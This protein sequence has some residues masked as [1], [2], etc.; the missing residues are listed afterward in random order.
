MRAIYCSTKVFCMGR[1][2]SLYIRGDQ[3]SKEAAIEA[4]FPVARGNLPPNCSKVAMVATQKQSGRIWLIGQVS[5]R[6]EKNMISMD[7]CEA[8]KI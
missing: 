1:L 3:R 7:I 8:N 4:D 2:D 6:I 5:R